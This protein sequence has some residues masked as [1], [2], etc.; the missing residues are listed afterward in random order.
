MIKFKCLKCKKDVPIFI[1]EACICGSQQIE[2][3]EYTTN[4]EF[5]KWWR[6]KGSKDRNEFYKKRKL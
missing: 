1:D 6:D 5:L 4:R 2:K 3:L